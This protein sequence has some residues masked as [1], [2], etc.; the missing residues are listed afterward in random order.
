MT[1]LALSSTTAYLVIAKNWE[2]WEAALIVCGVMSTLILAAFTTII[3]FV[4]HDERSQYLVD[5][6]KGLVNECN[7]ALKFLQIK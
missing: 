2:I 4:P 1:A 6:S 5:F 7:N 3:L